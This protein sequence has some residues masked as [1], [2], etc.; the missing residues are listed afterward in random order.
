MS[1]RISLCRDCLCLEWHSF[2]PDGGSYPR[3]TC[4][5]N[6]DKKILTR[7]HQDHS[8]EQSRCSFLKSAHVGGKPEPQAQYEERNKVAAE[9]NKIQWEE[10]QKLRAEIKR[11]ENEIDA[12]WNETDRLNAHCRVCNKVIR[13]I[14][15]YNGNRKKGYL[16]EEHYF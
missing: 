5:D 12:R 4:D 11:I 14:E 13:G 9:K 10:L 6:P 7:T 15:I 8:H 3:C 16:C 2:G 1:H